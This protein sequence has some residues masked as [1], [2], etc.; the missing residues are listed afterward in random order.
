VVGW[1]DLAGRPEEELEKLAANPIFRGIRHVL[2]DAPETMKNSA[3]ISGLAILASS[4]KVFDLLVLPNQ[5]RAA[6]SMIRSVPGIRIA[7][8]HAGKP[9]LKSEELGLWQDGMKRLSEIDNVYCKLSGLPSEAPGGDWTGTDYR[10]WVDTLLDL[11]GTKRLMFGS[12]WPT[13]T[14]VGASFDDIV[15]LTEKLVQKLS[16]SEQEEIFGSTARRCYRL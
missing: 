5:L 15:D 4:G 2:A 11:F 3:F 7:I 13:C 14:P 1:V 12:N 16:P 10:P 9:I 8:N 6:E